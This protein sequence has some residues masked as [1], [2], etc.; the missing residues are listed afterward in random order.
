MA[1]H[2]TLPGQA[3]GAQGDGGLRA[4]VHYLDERPPR[5]GEDGGGEAP[6]RG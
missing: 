6:C 5:E 2:S 3:T 4:H 1:R